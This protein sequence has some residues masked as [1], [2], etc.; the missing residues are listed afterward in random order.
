MTVDCGR[1]PAHD[2]EEEN[3]ATF[4][5]IPSP[6]IGPWTFPTA[7]HLPPPSSLRSYEIRPAKDVEVAM[8]LIAPVHWPVESFQTPS[9]QKVDCTM[10]IVIGRVA[11]LLD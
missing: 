8:P 10:V 4:Q 11:R 1:S 7:V 3:D 6:P 9:T 5:L 2:A